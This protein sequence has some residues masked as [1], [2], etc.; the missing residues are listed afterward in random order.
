MPIPRNRFLSPCKRDQVP[1][2]LL[3]TCGLGTILRDRILYPTSLKQ[4][5]LYRVFSKAIGSFNPTRDLQQ[6]RQDQ[7]CTAPVENGA[8]TCFGDEGSSLFTFQC[9]STKTDCLLGIANN[10]N[11]ESIRSKISTSNENSFT[12][13][14]CSR[15]SFFTSLPYMYNWIKQKIALEPPPAG[16]DLIGHQQEDS[17]ETH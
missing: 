4:I 8:N 2:T 11:W 12:F 15:G 17:Q 7:I 6:C 13:P 16:R 10:Y 1:G 9:G 3:S 14:N 5:G